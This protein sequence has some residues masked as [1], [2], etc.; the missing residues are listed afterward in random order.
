MP[1][2]FYQNSFDQR[3]AEE[4]KFV[5][6]LENSKAPPLRRR[7]AENFELFSPVEDDLRGFSVLDG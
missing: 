2:G 5:Q 3:R 7:A 4:L 1:K 6:E